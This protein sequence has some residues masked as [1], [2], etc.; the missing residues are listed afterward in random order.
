MQVFHLV[1]RRITVLLNHFRP[2]NFIRMTELGITFDVME[3]VVKFGFK[4]CDTQ[5]RI[6]KFA[7]TER[8][9]DYY[10]CVNPTPV[11]SEEWGEDSSVLL[12]FYRTL[13]F[14]PERFYCMKVN[15]AWKY[16]QLNGSNGEHTNTDDHDNADRVRVRKEANNHL[17]QKPRN[18]H[19]VGRDKRRNRH[20]NNGQPNAGRGNRDQNVNNN[21]VNNRNVNNINNVNEEKEDHVLDPN[22]GIEMLLGKGG[23]EKIRRLGTEELFQTHPKPEVATVEAP[24]DKPVYNM[25]VSEETLRFAITQIYDLEREV[26]AYRL[27]ITTLEDKEAHLAELLLARGELARRLNDIERRRRELEYVTSVAGITRELKRRSDED[28][29]TREDERIEDKWRLSERELARYGLRIVPKVTGLLR[30]KY[31]EIFYGV[32]F[33]VR[34]LWHMFMCQCFI[35][36]KFLYSFVEIEKHLVHSGVQLMIIYVVMAL[37]MGLEIILW[38][39]V[40]HNQGFSQRVRWRVWNPRA[41]SISTKVYILAVI[42]SYAWTLPYTFVLLL[43]TF[44]TL[45]VE[46]NPEYEEPRAEVQRTRGFIRAGDVVGLSR[47]EDQLVVDPYSQVVTVQ[48]NTRMREKLEYEFAGSR[49]SINLIGNCRHVLYREFKEYQKFKDFSDVAENTILVFYYER[50][51]RDEHMRHVVMPANRVQEI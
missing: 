32:R 8:L 39:G 22:L 17:H 16:G 15:Q 5:G 44:F 48:I 34:G 49:A 45:L 50:L 51:L 4:V 11:E 3:G 42:L 14:M 27:T 23:K 1:K 33:F 19:G 36:E 18:D 47:D 20:V 41:A 7:K 9:M 46:P 25:H 43:F 31:S 38:N 29:Q 2:T 12:H 21:N 35:F 30:W 24:D 10:N 26:E 13:W 40:M 6:K 28:I 37:A